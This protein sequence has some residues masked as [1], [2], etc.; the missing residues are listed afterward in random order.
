MTAYEKAL[1]QAEALDY[2]KNAMDNISVKMNRKEGA[3]YIDADIKYALTLD[4]YF[5]LE[6][7]NNEVENKFN[8]SFNL[9]INYIYNNLTK[10]DAF[11]YFDYA[12]SQLLLESPFFKAFKEF[13]K[14][15]VDNKFIVYVDQISD[16]YEECILSIKNYLAGL[17]FKADVKLEESQEARAAYENMIK[18]IIDSNN[19][20]YEEQKAKAI[21][22]A[23]VKEFAVS[24]KEEKKFMPSF[25]TI[26]ICNIPNNLVDLARYKNET[27]EP[28]FK[29]VGSIFKSEVK[30]LKKSVLFTGAITDE[31]DSI[32]F[33]K[34]PRG[35]NA[36]N[37]IKEIDKSVNKGKPVT[38]ELTGKV[39]YDD[40]T[41]EILLNVKDI[42]P[43]SVDSKSYPKDNAIEKRVELSVHTKM[44][45]LD[46]L[47]EPGEYFQCAKA[48]GH[49]AVG[50]TDH[51]GVYAIPKI[52]HE[53]CPEVK[54]LIGCDFDYI[55]D[56]EAHIT[57]SDDDINLKSASYVVF[58]IEATGLS[59]EYSEIIEIAAYKVKD[60]IIADKFEIFINPLRHIPEKIT[61]LT[62][63][64]DE[65]VADAP[66]IKEGIE[67]FL[68]FIDGSILVAH[69]ADYDIGMIHAKMRQNGIQ[70]RPIPGIDTLN[71]FR[72]LHYDTEKKFGLKA[73]SKFY[74]IKQEHHH[75][76]TDD[77]RVLCECF[78]QMLQELSQRQITNYNE[79]NN[80][81]KND[82]VLVKLIPNRM[83]VIAKTQAGYKNLFKLVSDALTVHVADD[84][85]LFQ[86]VLEKYSDGIIKLSGNSFS[87]VFEYALNGSEADLRRA[88]KKYDVIEV[89]PPVSLLH[90]IDDLGEDGRKIV[91]EVIEKICRISKEEGKLVCATGEVY[92]IDAA[93][94][95][96]R[97]ILIDSPKVGGGFHELAG[98]N[99]R[100][101]AHYMTT[102]EMLKEFSFLPEDLAYEIVVTNTN[103]VADMVENISCFHKEMFVPADDEFADHPDP[104]L[105]FP[106]MIE[107]MKEVVKNNMLKKY[108]ENVHPYVDA[109]IKRELD[110]II[111]SGYYS[112]YF[113][114]YL[115]VKDSNDHGYLVG[116]RGSVGSSFAATMMGITEVNP[117]PPHYLCPNVNLWLLNSIHMRK[118]ISSLRRKEP[119]SLF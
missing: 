91:E 72:A 90:I 17:N 13:S 100:P 96:Y 32:T 63:I 47:N 79:L 5:R 110:A 28:I 69:N 8:V 117:L 33:K 18:S 81:I 114:A 54:P 67:E 56:L 80:L 36:I 76:A 116:S 52:D 25:E 12:V 62:S 16:T 66:L 31:T 40:Y 57:Y 35:E 104:S 75:R 60:G 103:K 113:M 73:L 111:K 41:K 24:E 109:R 92:Y 70:D 9:N 77:T 44:S 88:I 97:E 74:K 106:S 21:E 38:V 7:A 34:F 48:M 3:F 85:R 19:A 22:N 82:D 99:V 6:K 119:L 10:D 39:E 43:I 112:T 84:A 118:V 23:K 4:E 68:K 1:A 64:T 30:E 65:M 37:S 14:D 94:K 115:M 26:N 11:E 83:S 55:D 87:D 107:G 58:D 27:G 102:E 49:T 51:N 61:G 15:Y 78:I 93:D 95:K 20:R 53:R 105:R 98:Y 50:F 42:T 86:S 29:I 59:Q 108:G 2:S 71:L 45:N 101:A 46:G 89:Q